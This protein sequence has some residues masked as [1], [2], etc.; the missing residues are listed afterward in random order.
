MSYMSDLT[1]FGKQL[2]SLRLF[3]DP[4]IVLEQTI[5]RVRLSLEIGPQHKKHPILIDLEGET[6]CFGPFHILWWW[7]Q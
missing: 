6:I 3:K 2:V 7:Q 4:W 1:E 5:G